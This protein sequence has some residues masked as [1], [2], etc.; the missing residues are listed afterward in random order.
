MGFAA[1]NPS[2][3][4]IQY[5]FLLQDANIVRKDDA[6]IQFRF[7]NRAVAFRNSLSRAVAKE[8]VKRRVVNLR[9]DGATIGRN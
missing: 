4:W 8:F 3:N 5:G 6:F 1:L 7:N 9:A 2:Y